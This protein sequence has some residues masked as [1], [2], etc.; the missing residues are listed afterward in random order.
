MIVR[1]AKQV[2]WISILLEKLVNICISYN[3]HIAKLGQSHVTIYI[4]L[5]LTQTQM[6]NNLTQ[7]LYICYCIIVG[8]W[9]L[10]CTQLLKLTSS[11]LKVRNCQTTCQL[12]TGSKTKPNCD[13]LVHAFLHFASA[14]WIF[15]QF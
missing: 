9:H 10:V 4:E 1:R 14:T 2:S 13:S 8:V 15:L 11:E 3:L 12:S 6:A 5:Y 7:E